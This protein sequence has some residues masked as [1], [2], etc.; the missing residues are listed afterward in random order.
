MFLE[1]GCH[2]SQ[3]RLGGAEPFSG[4][5]GGCHEAESQATD[6]VG[7]GG[8]HRDEDA[9]EEVLPGRVPSLLGTQRDRSV[10]G[11]Q[12]VGD[13]AKDDDHE[14]ADWIDFDPSAVVLGE[15]GIEGVVTLV[16]DGPETTQEEVPATRQQTVRREAADIVALVWVGAAGGAWLRL[17]VAAR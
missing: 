4:S 10:E 2:D 8:H 9:R 17:D 5:C 15:D 1:S 11:E 7:G 3:P 13:A 14:R 12:G 16:L 6:D